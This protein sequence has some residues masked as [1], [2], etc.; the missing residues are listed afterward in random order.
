[1]RRDKNECQHRNKI[2]KDKFQEEVG[3]CASCR[4]KFSPC[5]SKIDQQPD[6][7]LTQ[8]CHHLDRRGSCV[9]DK[10]RKRRRKMS[11][12]WRASAPSCKRI[13]AWSRRRLPE[14]RRGSKSP[15]ISQ[16]GAKPPR[17]RADSR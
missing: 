16:D 6:M 8:R 9:S 10:D 17:P 3:I 15:L 11:R 13:D 5:N 1:M 7:A 4:S 2:I 12:K 14:C